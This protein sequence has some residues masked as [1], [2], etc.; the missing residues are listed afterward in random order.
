[1]LYSILTG[2]FKDS[3]DKIEKARA[4]VLEELMSAILKLLLDTM[5]NQISLQEPG[6]VSVNNAKLIDQTTTIA[7]AVSVPTEVPQENKK[8]E[9]VFKIAGTHVD[10]QPQTKSPRENK[11]KLRPR[12]QESSSNNKPRGLLD[13]AALPVPKAVPAPPPA[14]IR[15][16]EQNATYYK[17]ADSEQAFKEFFEKNPLIIA[18]STSTSNLNLILSYAEFTDGSSIEVG[19]PQGITNKVPPGSF[20]AAVVAGLEYYSDKNDY[21]FESIKDLIP[22][23]NDAH[24]KRTENASE[25]GINEQIKRSGLSLQP[26]EEKILEIM[27]INFSYAF[28]TVDTPPRVDVHN[29]NIR[30][31]TKRCTAIRIQNCWLP[32]FSVLQTPSELKSTFKKTLSIKELKDQ[33]AFRCG[34]HTIDPYELFVSEHPDGR[35]K[36][37]GI[38]LNNGTHWVIMVPILDNGDP[39]IKANWNWKNGDSNQNKFKLLDNPGGGAC[40]L[41]SLS[42]FL[43]DQNAKKKAVQEGHLNNGEGVYNK[44]KQDYRGVMGFPETYEDFNHLW[45]SSGYT[46]PE[47]YY[48]RHG[49]PPEENLVVLTVATFTELSGEL[50]TWD[51][52]YKHF[53]RHNFYN[54]SDAGGV[55]Q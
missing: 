30:G 52:I 37:D 31:A 48:G 21:T 46:D 45:A 12:K 1:M 36:I 22:Y 40:L 25:Q 42:Y 47:K 24:Q 4:E 15:K 13:Q 26:S 34:I 20:L 11:P 19:I 49:I 27:N 51:Q 6:E 16:R 10:S 17:L 54:H 2:R 50:K 7:N 33:F 5:L 18:N 55:V 3:D 38:L 29:K 43:G 39:A 41:H 23:N 32:L 44:F 14:R 8:E 35:P 28:L 9:Y 53:M